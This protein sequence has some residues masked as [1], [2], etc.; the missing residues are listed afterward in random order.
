MF[1]GAVFQA[2]WAQ[3]AP[4]NSSNRQISNFKPAKL[5]LSP[6]NVPM[7]TSPQGSNAFLG[8]GTISLCPVANSYL[9][10]DVTH[11]FEEQSLVRSG[12]TF[13]LCIL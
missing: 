5:T 2:S 6:R 13:K 9:I 7:P 12:G 1:S 11:L 8:L 4:Q 3:R 10:S